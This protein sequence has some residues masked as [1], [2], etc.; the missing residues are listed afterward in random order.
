VFVEVSSTN[1]HI[2]L[3]RRR[4]WILN[5]IHPSLIWNPS[6]LTEAYYHPLTSRATLTLDL[7]TRI[8]RSAC[9]RYPLC[10]SHERARSPP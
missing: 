8:R 6:D 9:D 1:R 7:T 10:V 4:G 2:R 3:S 5:S